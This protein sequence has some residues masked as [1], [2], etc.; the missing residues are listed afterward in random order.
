MTMR[1]SLKICIFIYFC[2][3][4]VDLRAK[5]AMKVEENYHIKEKIE[6]F[7]KQIIKYN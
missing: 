1:N 6:K 4:I 7:L 2:L 3:N 5:L